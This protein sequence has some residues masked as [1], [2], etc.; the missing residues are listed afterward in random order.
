MSTSIPNGFRFRTTDLGEV[1]A[2]L[3]RWRRRVRADAVRMA[4]EWLAREGV[5]LIDGAVASGREVPE[6]PLVEAGKRWNGLRE[7]L[8]KRRREPEVDY[9]FQIGI[10]PHD[11]ALYGILHTEQRAW[12]KDWFAED[13]VEPM[14]YWNGTDGPED[15][16]EADWDA[17]GRLWDAIMPSGIPANHGLTADLHDP[18][19]MKPPPEAVL[20][21][22][23][24]FED[25]VRGTA[26]DQVVLARQRALREARG[27]NDDDP[28]T[29]AMQDYL[30]ARRW[31]AK[32]PEGQAAVAAEEARLRDL[33][34]REVTHFMFLGWGPGDPA[35]EA[36]ETKV[37][38]EIRDHADADRA[39]PAP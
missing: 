3:D 21:A 24:S 26:Y 39:P 17:R 35:E 28:T 5:D 6:Q 18:W 19:F 25:R 12:R 16:S 36:Q 32:A 9:D 4:A 38:D 14:P 27:G 10:L 30:R 20:A 37:E 8:Q 23:P 15:M 33:L 34:P 2:L 13:L 11:G 22:L 31:A 1:M 29:H 7:N